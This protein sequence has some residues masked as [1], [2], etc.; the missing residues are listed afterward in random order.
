MVYLEKKRASTMMQRMWDE[1]YSQKLP[2]GWKLVPVESLASCAIA[3]TTTH[4]K[5]IRVLQSYFV[6]ITREDDA[7]EVLAHEVAHALLGHP[8]CVDDMHNSLWSAMAK[9]LRGT[10]CRSMFVMKP[11]NPLVEL[12]RQMIK[13]TGKDDTAMQLS[14]VRNLMEQGHSA[15]VV[16]DWYTDTFDTFDTYE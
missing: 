8:A 10:G 6:G 13:E 4:D 5:T 9:S 15:Q 1:R 3:E 14:A 11:D 12:I 2:S 7:C 16:M